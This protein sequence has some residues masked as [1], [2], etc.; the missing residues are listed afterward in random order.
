MNQ[1]HSMKHSELAIE[2]S[3]T[4]LF[5]QKTWSL[6]HA[7]LSALHASNQASITP[8]LIIIKGVGLTGYCNVWPAPAQ[9]TSPYLDWLYKL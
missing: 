7:I 6:Y 8:V 5:W 4:I 3:M 2:S 1:Q 9:R